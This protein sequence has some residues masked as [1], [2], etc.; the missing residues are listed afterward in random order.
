MFGLRG[1][2]V[3][4]SG[5]RRRNVPRCRVSCAGPVRVCESTD[6]ILRH[7]FGDSFASGSAPAF[8]RFNDRRIRNAKRHVRS[9]TRCRAGRSMERRS[10]R[11]SR[12]FSRRIRWRCFPALTGNPMILAAE[13]ERSPV[14]WKRR[15]Q[16]VG[17]RFEVSIV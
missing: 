5:G 17:V 14:G 11:S 9:C 4:R 15:A 12:S 8:D 1:C 6:Y 16:R 10:E 2:V 3:V 7:G 13:D